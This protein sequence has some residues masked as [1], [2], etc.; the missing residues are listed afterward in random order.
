MFVAKRDQKDES[1]PIT[2]VVRNPWRERD[3]LVFLC[4]VFGSED[5]F[6]EYDILSDRMLRKQGVETLIE[7]NQEP[8]GPVA[9]LIYCKMRWADL[10]TIDVIIL[11]FSVV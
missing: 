6:H 9:L 1:S 7:I 3:D 11:H 5:A 8:V 10:S 2:L 4:A